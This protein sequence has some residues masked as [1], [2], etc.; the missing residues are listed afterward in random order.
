[1]PAGPSVNL[2]ATRGDVVPGEPWLLVG[3]HLDTVPQAPGRRGQ[4]LGDRRA[5]GGRRG[6]SPGTGPGCR[7]CWWRS[8][9]RSRA[10][11]PTPTTT[12]AR[13]P[14]SRRSTPRS[15]RTAARHGLA[16]PGRRRRTVVPVGSA[17][18]PDALSDELAGRGPAGRRA[19]PWSTPTS[20]RATTGRS[21]GRGCRAPGSAARRTPA[22]TR[23]PTCPSVVDPAQLERTAATGRAWLAAAGPRT[24]R[25]WRDHT[26]ARMSA[27]RGLRSAWREAA[28]VHPVGHQPDRLELGAPERRLEH[29]A[30][31]ASRSMKSMSK[32]KL[33]SECS[34]GT[35]S[36][37]STPC[38]QCGWPPTTRSAP[39]ATS[40]RATVRWSGHGGA[41]TASPQCGSTT[42]TS[43]RRS[44]PSD[45]PLDPGQVG[46]DERPG[47]RR[48]PHRQ[49]TRASPG[50]P[51]RLADRVEAEEGVRRPVR[52]SRAPPGSAASARSSPAPNGRIRLCC[53]VAT[54]CRSARSP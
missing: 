26:S 46:L 16:G 48:H 36:T 31:H 5:A 49:R 33:P 44:R 7:S 28:G 43:A 32:T 20:G 3:A 25:C 47:A 10:G 13:R 17:Y 54:V 15:A 29:D 45:R 19:A 41:C 1:M 22:T 42:T 21:C 14:T 12:T 11:R 35:P 8:A 9:P 51:R 4:R 18:E 40:R 39:A 52:R 30:L 50:R 38:T 53:R 34:T 23:P 27:P 2:I 6:A 37:A 24:D